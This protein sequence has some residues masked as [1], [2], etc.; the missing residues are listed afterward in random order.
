MDVFHCFNFSFF[1]LS[2]AIQCPKISKIT[3]SK[4][5]H[6]IR[7]F[8]A[9]TTVECLEGHV[10]PDNTTSAVLECLTGSVWNAFHTSCQSKRFLLPCLLVLT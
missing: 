10:F 6:L 4:D 9:K 1:F 8:G 3:N 2:L 7:M 5:Y